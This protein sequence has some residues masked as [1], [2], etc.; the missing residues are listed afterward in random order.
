M[1]KSAGVTL[2]GGNDDEGKR[3]SLTLQGIEGKKE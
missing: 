2:A 1:K 3:S